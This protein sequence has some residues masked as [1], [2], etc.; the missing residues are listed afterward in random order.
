MPEKHYLLKVLGLSGFPKLVTFCLTLFSFPLLMRELGAE[1]YGT[2]LFIGS[3]LSLFE[4][5]VD[6][7][8][9]SAAGKSMAAVRAHQ[10]A[11]IR[12]EFFVWARLQVFFV[13][14]GFGPMLLA[15]YLMVKGSPAFQD[16]ILLLVMSSAVVFRVILNFIR[17]NLQS[18]LAYKSLAVLD[19]TE[20]IIRSSGFLLVAFLYPSALGLASAALA[21]AVLSSI[22]AIVLIALRLSAERGRDDFDRRE[23]THDW[24]GRQVTL[25]SRLRESTN[26]L[27]LRISTRFFQEGPMLILGRLLG[28][29]IVGVVGAF[30]KVSE[31]M[32]TLYLVIGNALMVRVNE[33]ASQGEQALRSLWDTAMRI[34]STSLFFAVLIF[35]VSEPLAKM[36]LP[37]SGMAP[38]MF[39]V[40]SA[41][42]FLHALSGVI[43]PMSDY[44]GGLTSRNILLSILSV[45]QVLVLWLLARYDGGQ[46]VVGAMVVIYGLVSTGNV[47]IAA[48]VF[49]GGYGIRLQKT[50]LSFSALVLCAGVV[51]H[52]VV[53]ADLLLEGWVLS[54]DVVSAL[55]C[56]LAV[57]IGI[58]TIEPVRKEY[59]NYH[60]FDISI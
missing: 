16:T 15:A 25:K 31:I 57:V 51:S 20:S 9:S 13:V 58:L 40:M 55:A 29:E 49:F 56:T 39:A 3:A 52:Y 26:F 30:R 54:G 23:D 17:P 44:M 24:A 60:F 37:Q 42:V 50:A 19:I 8:I 34:V 32:S 59:I 38:Q 21:T 45:I 43:S 46:S 7:G 36:L 1:A 10:P 11:A 6:F 4:A 35:L 18:L 14:F 33:V 22:L 47:M 27:W 53:H 5:L 48:H 12:R 28:P 41:L 2:V